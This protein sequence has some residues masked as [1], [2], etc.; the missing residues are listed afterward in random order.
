MED[1]EARCSQVCLWRPGQYV[2]CRQ[3]RGRVDTFRYSTN[4]GKTWYVRQH[5][6]LPRGETN[7][8]IAGKGCALITIPDSFSQ[9]FHL[10][11]II[12]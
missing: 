3:C 10:L 5:L 1:S 8:E 4:L 7:A 9:K 11:A 12:P 6:V 2:G